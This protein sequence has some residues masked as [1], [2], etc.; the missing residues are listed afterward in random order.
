MEKNFSSYQFEWD[1]HNIEKNWK[2]HKVRFSEC[3]E[4]FLNEPLILAEVD[5]SK[6]LYREERQ[7]AYGQSNVGRSLFVVFTI[8]QEM[9]RVISA[10]DMN[11]K[12][13][14][15]YEQEAKKSS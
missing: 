8:R 14:R 9:I 5:K 3:E 15:F 12:E 13:R 6:I 10:R 11:R 2:K 7:L 4:V 1:N